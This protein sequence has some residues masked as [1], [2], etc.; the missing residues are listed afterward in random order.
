VQKAVKQVT[1]VAEST[2]Q[3]VTDTAVKAAKTAASKKR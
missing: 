2:L 3:A 1:Q